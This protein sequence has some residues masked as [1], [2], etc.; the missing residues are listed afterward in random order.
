[1]KEYMIGI[2]FISLIF[3]VLELIV[4]KPEGAFGEKG[5][6][7]VLLFFS[8]LTPL[9]G[10]LKPQ[11]EKFPDFKTEENNSGEYIEV[12]KEAFEEGIKKEIAEKYSIKSEYI[13]VASVDFSFES[14]RA[15]EIHVSLSARA[16]RLD[17]KKVEEYINS[18][19]IGRCYVSFEIG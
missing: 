15:G 1:V 18:F 4:Y 5:A 10:I 9:A 14:M 13:T 12:A 6:L 7:A 8:V 2:F 11:T 19:N 17:P 3:G 16:G